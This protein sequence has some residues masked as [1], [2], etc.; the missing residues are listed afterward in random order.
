MLVTLCGRVGM[1]NPCH[2]CNINRRIGNTVQCLQRS[3]NTTP[4]R[5]SSK[6]K[7]PL[8]QLNTYDKFRVAVCRGKWKRMK[9]VPDQLPREEMYRLGSIY[10]IRAN[11]FTAF[12][13]GVAFFYTAQKGSIKNEMKEEDHKQEM[14]N[15]QNTFHT[16]VESSKK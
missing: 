2:G 4:S 12:L 5:S 7:E 6:T 9:D 15:N 8:H 11:I 1:Y 10:R 13:M 16:Y 3:L 14:A